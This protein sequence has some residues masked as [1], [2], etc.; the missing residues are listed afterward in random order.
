MLA[1]GRLAF[2]QNSRLGTPAEWAALQVIAQS[3][4]MSCQLLPK[5]RLEIELRDVV[6]E[7][8]AE[9]RQH[10]AIIVIF[11]VA[12]TIIVINTGAIVVTIVATIAVAIITVIVVIVVRIMVVLTFVV[13]ELIIASSTPSSSTVTYRT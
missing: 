13:I 10:V 6:T 1:T 3:T 8:A 9:S 5:D 2:L 4:A 7:F 11:I 12:F